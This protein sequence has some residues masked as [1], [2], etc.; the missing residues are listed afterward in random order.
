NVNV[1][2]HNLKVT[3]SWEYGKEQPQ[4]VFRVKIIG[5]SDIHRQWNTTDHQYDLTKY[6]WTSQDRYMD[7]YHVKV[8]AI[9]G[10]EES[11]VET[12][13]T[14]SFNKLKTTSLKSGLLEFPLVKLNEE[15]SVATVH[16]MNPYHHYKELKQA[17][18]SDFASFAITVTSDAGDQT[19]D[20][21]AKEEYCKHKVTFRE[22]VEKCVTL[23]KGVLGATNYIGSVWFNKTGPIC[24]PESAAI[25]VITLVT[26][27]S[28]VVFIIAAVII[29]ICKVR[30]WTMDAP[31]LPKPLLPNRREQDLNYDK[32]SVVHVTVEPAFKSYKDSSVSSEEE[33]SPTEKHHDCSASSDFEHSAGEKEDFQIAETKIWK[34]QRYQRDRGQ[35]MTQ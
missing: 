21:S 34:L 14:F 25:H 9:Q 20:C 33:D 16:F 6:I 10:E 19:F 4:T 18:K 1:N 12:S 31:S 26:L 11:G 29:C 24:V 28:V 5:S 27:L 2:C 17:S 22:G 23:E 30:A 3:V 13:Q 32:V 35:M 8:S 7:L 15:D